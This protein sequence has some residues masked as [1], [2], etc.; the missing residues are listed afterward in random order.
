M[1]TTLDSAEICALLP[2]AGHMC[3]LEHVEDWNEE[4][5]RAV[6]V[7]H[8]LPHHPLAREGGVSGVHALEYGAQAM[9]VHAALLA[10]RAG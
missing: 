10:R 7:S 8:R 4:R 3:L 5:L 1:A 2:H 6:T 9:A